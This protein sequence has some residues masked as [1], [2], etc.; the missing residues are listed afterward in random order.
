MDAVPDKDDLMFVLDGIKDDE[1][2]WRDYFAK[3]LLK[4]ANKN[5][6]WFRNFLELAHFIKEITGKNAKKYNCTWGNVINALNKPTKITIENE[7]G[8]TEKVSEKVKDFLR[9]P[10]VINKYTKQLSGRFVLKTY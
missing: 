3:R 9:S 5:D 8:K 10:D 2:Q 1:N 7:D 4:G 6:T